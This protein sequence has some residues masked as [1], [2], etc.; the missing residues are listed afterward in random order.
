MRNISTIFGLFVSMLVAVSALAG[1]V[2]LPHTFQPNTKA[3]ASEVNANFNAVRDAVND[4]NN[5]IES[6]ENFSGNIKNNSC[7]SG[8]AVTGFDN[9]GVLQCGEFVTA[10]PKYRSITVHAS[11]CVPYGS[12]NKFYIE[13]YMSPDTASGPSLVDA[14]C[15]IPIPEGVTLKYIMVKVQDDDAGTGRE[16]LV[17]LQRIDYL[18]TAPTIIK[19]LSTDSDLLPGSIIMASSINNVYIDRG[20][21]LFL[22]VRMSRDSG[23]NLKFYGATIVYEYDPLYNGSAPPP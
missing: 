22:L 9:N 17:Q 8:E 6:L 21:S 14:Y 11:S 19:E 18:N 15:N 4:N 3:K 7:V 10:N 20:D 12:T 2:N 23:N 5:R 1:E 16:I 13:T